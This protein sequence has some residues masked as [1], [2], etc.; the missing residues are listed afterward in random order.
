MSSKPLRNSVMLDSRFPV[1]HDAIRLLKAVPA[2]GER[3]AFLRSLV[4][5]GYS[6][7]CQGREPTARSRDQGSHQEGGAHE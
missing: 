3:A 2:K 1:E 5:I 7:L 4:L 6:D